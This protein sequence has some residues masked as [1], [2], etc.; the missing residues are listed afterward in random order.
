MDKR[1]EVFKLFGPKLLEGF[2]GLI[3]K[4]INELRTAAGLPPRTKIQAHDEI[5]NDAQHLPDYD[6]TG[7]E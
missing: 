6:W 3:L 5:M 7:K 4:E 2:L 1:S